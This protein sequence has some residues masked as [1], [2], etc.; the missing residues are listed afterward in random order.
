MQYITAHQDRAKDINIEIK[1]QRIM[2]YGMHTLLIILFAGSLAAC[3]RNNDPE[4]P[5]LPT[6]ISV[7]VSEEAAEEPAS[8]EE[9]VNESTDEESAPAEEEADDDEAPAQE[10]AAEESTDEEAEP[11]DEESAADEEA[12]ATDEAAEESTDE[13]AEPAEEV[14]PRVFFIQPTD[15]AI[16]P[17]TSTIVMGVEGLD[18]EPA[19]E[20]REGAGHLHILV[21]TD[22]IAPG[23]VIPSD[24]LHLHYGKG[25]LSAE[26]GLTPGEHT[27]RL[28]FANGAHIALEGDQYRA[29]INVTV[30]EDAAEKGVYFV[31]PNEGDTVSSPIEV[32]MAASGVEIEPA[33]DIRENAGHLH[34]LVNTEFIVPG[35][36]IVND[37]THLHYGKAQ[38]ETTL[39]L[40]P[41]EYVLRLQLAN[42]AHIAL[43]GEEYQDE[44]NIIVE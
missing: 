3:G 24:E 19:G 14:P 41:G 32:I 11:A 39:E 8:A 21:D 9:A 44:I 34:I 40:E 6:A 23:E 10:E 4:P 20:I 26:V 12:P 15:Y 13:E 37:E 7:E 28:Q 36:V 16:L 2:R 18:V 35:E 31:T 29:E 27:L 17:I 22:F 33:G 1:M 42:G 25:Q 5:T 38:T 30:T 43:E